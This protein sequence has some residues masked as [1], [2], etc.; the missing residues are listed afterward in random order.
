MARWRAHL[1][2]QEDGG[3]QKHWF[4][5][6]PTA[7]ALW[8]PENLFEDAYREHSFGM[9]TVVQYVWWA[10]VGDDEPENVPWALLSV[11]WKG[12][13]ASER[14]A[15][16]RAVTPLSATGC[17]D[18]AVGWPEEPG[19]RAKTFSRGSSQAVGAKRCGRLIAARGLGF[20]PVEG[21]VHDVLQSHA[22]D[23]DVG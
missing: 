12:G 8:K 5:T 3:S 11:C 16:R 13:W 15:A 21:N 17:N 1:R 9:S 2:V 14:Q 22:Y 7:N 6:P 4:P 23:L 10:I 18:A 20:T 19:G